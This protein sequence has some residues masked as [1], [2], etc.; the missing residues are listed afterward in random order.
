MDSKGMWTE[1]A[2]S[3]GVS[4][5]ESFRDNPNAQEIARVEYME[6]LKG[7]L[8][9]SGAWKMIGKTVDGHLVTEA[10]LIAAAWKEGAGAVKKF[11]NDE[12]TNTEAN[13]NILFR[14]DQFAETSLTNERAAQAVATTASTSDRAQTVGHWE[15]QVVYTDVGVPLTTQ[16]VWVPGPDPRAAPLSPASEPP[17]NH[18]T[19]G[20]IYLSRDG[21]SA[22]LPDGQVVNAGPGGRLELGV[23]GNLSATRPVTGY[24]VDERVYSITLHGKSGQIIAKT[25]VQVI[26]DPMYPDD[27][28]RSTTLVQGQT[29]DI[30]QLQPDG[31]NTVIR[32]VFQTGFGWVEQGTGELVQS[33]S[34]WRQERPA[35]TSAPPVAPTEAPTVPNR[36]ERADQPEQPEQPEQTHQDSDPDPNSADLTVPDLASQF[37]G[38]LNTGAYGAGQLGGLDVLPFNENSS[39]LVNADGDMVAEIT[40]LPTGY[41]QL[42]GIDGTVLYISEQSG[43]VYTQDEYKQAQAGEAAN[44]I[45]LVGSIIG[46]QHWGNMSDLQRT[47]AV[48]SIYHAVDTIAGGDKLPLGD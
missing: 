7:E 48:V 11:F 37:T 17:T 24:D 1:E 18:T 39:F 12:S 8:K 14:L 21:A 4:S 44:A 40:T 42:K 13:K 10:G 34:E 38:T 32:T 15:E 43:R 33:I 5:P 20:S 25:Q 9:S 3:H 27:A 29:R 36:S 26:V 31:S 41:R 30:T 16:M 6:K 46:L 19:A 2:L 45:G 23:D 22:T 47:A 28:A 35:Q